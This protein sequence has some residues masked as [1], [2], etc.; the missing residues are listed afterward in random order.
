MMVFSTRLGGAR[1][2]VGDN[3]SWIQCPVGLI[4]S[5]LRAASLRLSMLRVTLSAL[6]HNQSHIR[7]QTAK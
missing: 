1:T 6:S 2:A 4:E 3:R 7:S 5:I